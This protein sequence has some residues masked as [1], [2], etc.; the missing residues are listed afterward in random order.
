[1]SWEHSPVDE[2]GFE[3]VYAVKMAK[4]SAWRKGVDRWVRCEFSGSTMCHV[5]QG[6]IDKRGKLT[7]KSS[8]GKEQCRNLDRWGFY[9]ASLRLSRK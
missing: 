2:D 3:D 7:T 9:P 5:P 1:M 6:Y 8:K 4:A